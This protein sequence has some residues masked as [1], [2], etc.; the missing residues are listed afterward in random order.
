MNKYLKVAPAN[1]RASRRGNTIGASVI[2]LDW[3]LRVCRW[4]IKF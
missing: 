4:H 2:P 3:A 1:D